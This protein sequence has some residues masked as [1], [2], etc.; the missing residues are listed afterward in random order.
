MDKTQNII[1]EL[2]LNSVEINLL[3][4]ELDKNIENIKN[5]SKHGCGKEAK[6]NKLKAPY[7]DRPSKKILLRASEK[8]YQYKKSE[9]IFIL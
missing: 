2:L 1:L 6:G 8:P 9:R 3:Q 4:E 7:K 5:E